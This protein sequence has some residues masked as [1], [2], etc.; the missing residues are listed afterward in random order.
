MGRDGSLGLYEGSMSPKAKKLWSAKMASRGNAQSEYEMVY[1]GRKL[2]LTKD[3]KV[4]VFRTI[5]WTILQKTLLKVDRNPNPLLPR[6]T[7]T[8]SPI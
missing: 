7:A 1:T 5:L 2:F 4:G 3:G 6:V 8:V